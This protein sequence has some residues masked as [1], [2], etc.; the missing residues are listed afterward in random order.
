M[1]K[2]KN[3]KAGV[4][5]VLGYLFSIAVASMVMVSSIIITNNIIEE[6]KSQVAEIEAQRIANYVANAISD[7]VAAKQSMPNADYH[8]KLDLPSAIGGMSYGIQ[9]TDTTVSVVSSSGR[10]LASS[11]TY[12]ANALG[13]SIANNIVYGSDIEISYEGSQFVRTLDFGTGNGYEHSP[14]EAG[15]FR[16]DT[17]R[18]DYPSIGQPYWQDAISPN[19]IPIVVA[20]PSDYNFTDATVKIVLNASNFDYGNATVIPQSKS[21][22]IS[23]VSGI[24]GSS[25]TEDAI[26]ADQFASDMRLYEY[27]EK[28]PSTLPYY[29]AV[30][31]SQPSWYR[32]WELG[33][34]EDVYTYGG[35]KT[36]DRDSIS[37]NITSINSIPG[38]K[39]NVIWNSIKLCEQG[40]EQAVEEGMAPYVN[41]FK[42]SSS[43]GEACF[44]R[45]QVFDKLITPY[46]IDDGKTFALD[47]FGYVANYPSTGDIKM[48]I[49]S[50]TVQIKYGDIYVDSEVPSLEDIQ[51]AIDEAAATPG[52]DVIYLNQ[53]EDFP[54]FSCNYQSL[55][56]NTPVTLVGEY[57]N[58]DEAPLVDISG[59]RISDYILKILPGGS[60]T[61]LIML[62]FSDGGSGEG[63]YC[64]PPT[65]NQ[66]CSGLVLD[67]CN[68]VVVSNCHFRDNNGDGI[69]IYNANNNI[70]TNCESYDNSDNGLL[71]SGVGS[72][73]NCIMYSNFSYSP[74]NGIRLDG[75]ANK[76]TIYA[77]GA[78]HNIGGN[79]IKIY[80][81][82]SSGP[83]IDNEIVDCDI[84]GNTGPAADGIQISSDDQGLPWNPDPNNIYVP[85]YNNIT[86]CKIHNNGESSNAAAGIFLFYTIYNNITDCEIYDTYGAGI[87]GYSS[88]YNKITDCSI[89]NTYNTITDCFGCGDG[90][91]F[92]ENFFMSSVENCNI[93]NNQE[94]GIRLNE[95]NVLHDPDLPSTRDDTITNCR[96]HDNNQAGINL[97]DT[98]RIY[99]SQCDIYRN[100]RDGIYIEGGD[101]DFG[102]WDSENP[103]G[104]GDE[105]KYCNIFANG[106]DGIH[107]WSGGTE[108]LG[109]LTCT[110]IHDNN[111]CANGIAAGHEGAGVYLGG[112][113]LNRKPSVS[114]IYH[115]NFLY[116]TSGDHCAYDQTLDIHDNQWDV[117]GI[118]NWWYDLPYNDPDGYPHFVYP[119]AN[120]PSY[121]FD[122]AAGP[123][124]RYKIDPRGALGAG[125]ITGDDD[126]NP[127]GPGHS[128]PTRRGI[129]LNPSTVIV[130]DGASSLC[131][132]ITDNIQDAINMVIDGGTVYVTGS[133]NSYAINGPL[134]I[135][136]SLRLIGIPNENGAYPTIKIAS[137]ACCPEPYAARTL[138]NI[139]GMSLDPA[140]A[141]KTI[142][143]ENITFDGQLSADRGIQINI[144]NPPATPDDYVSI[145]NCKFKNIQYVSTTYGQNGEAIYIKANNRVSVKNCVLTDNKYGIYQAGNDGRITDCSFDGNQVYGLYLAA[146]ASNNKIYH[147]Y[148]GLNSSNTKDAKNVSSGNLNNQWDNGY[149]SGGNRWASFDVASEGA[150]DSFHG[151]SQ[152]TLIGGDGI[153][154]KPYSI[155]GGG[156]D[157]FPLGGTVSGQ[158][159]VSPPSKKRSFAIDYWNSY[160][161]SIL[162]AKLSIAAGA[163][164]KLYLYY[165]GGKGNVETDS[166]GNVAE[167]YDTFDSAP[168]SSAK[169]NVLGGAPYVSSDGIL[170]LKKLPGGSMVP[171]TIQFIMS[172]NSY[173]SIPQVDQ[174]S[175]GN[176]EHTVNEELY[177]VEAS[178]KLNE[179]YSKNQAS[180]I[181]LSQSNSNY[182]NAYLVSIN[183]NA[184]NPQNP[185]NNLTIHK[186]K[187]VSSQF[188]K[189]LTSVNLPS[190]L[191]DWFRIKSYVYISSNIYA[192][193]QWHYNA[194]DVA[195]I[196]NTLFDLASFS[197]F[198][199][200][201]YMDGNNTKVDSLTV[202]VSNPIPGDFD[203]YDPWSS[204]GIGIGC[205]LL[206]SNDP[207]ITDGS[208]LVDWIRALKT[209]LVPPNVAVGAPESVLYYWSN[210]VVSAADFNSGNP[211]SP[212][213]LLRDYHYSSSTTEFI[214]NGLE[215]NAGYR[216][217]ITKGSENTI[218]P[219]MNVEILQDINILGTATFS[220]T[221]IQQYEAES[222]PITTNTNHPL[223]VRFSVVSGPGGLSAA[224]SW[225]A[226]NSIVIER[227]ERGIVIK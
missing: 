108:L 74:H 78:H 40:G 167:F 35:V 148:F 144:N 111:F 143:I 75:R 204:G 115:N 14:V 222:I 166:I 133:S 1:R 103:P 20:N 110:K 174:P 132:N 84:Y 80:S 89:Y 30:L 206:T 226:V 94:D 151:G 185:T 66:I 219:G 114:R 214:I 129:F 105:V 162:L 54:Y 15:S 48:F 50:S 189:N 46:G 145:S 137:F 182:N 176:N 168:L 25:S 22:S 24:V 119:G 188:E 8:K 59:T 65:N 113:L 95:L 184:T 76:N 63:G 140:V 153:V 180:L 181:L 177:L 149:P 38:L 127:Y 220:S 88:Y 193:D 157:R 71:I 175:P 13:V 125:W 32:Y 197:E 96:I 61:R 142:F 191:N 160:G 18:L 134:T 33:I 70:I 17:Y 158:E 192:Q 47:L 128:D 10:V 34:S 68:N 178:I 19:R 81:D 21:D 150:N 58:K 90:I 171:P 196:N 91:Y 117:N 118:G 211:S 207:T 121:L 53:S 57:L 216:I 9:V 136:K 126:D 77:C 194:T 221:S 190:S 23:G 73:R 203:G 51:A 27:D 72:S 29:P 67:G 164:K 79:G 112:S 131:P 69:L 36:R 56:I 102:R 104:P 165:G 42:Y 163:E 82:S 64:V 44:D 225:W 205:G 152:P 156:Q 39:S 146:T 199:Q 45:S 202:P 86:G 159:Q 3:N 37:F 92:G 169:W 172:K 26:Y 154:D 179:S 198:N 212:G 213:P 124:G 195:E 210:P 52:Q 123:N 208:V 106:D 135:T 161:E 122:H 49:G 97:T 11:S 217:S 218:L 120:D 62:T 170:E 183:A 101:P 85:K 187:Y 139:T 4:S 215:G 155:E 141:T 98:I 224:N 209:P 5:N 99:I 28:S 130:E 100:S 223:Y 200:S 6:K 138:I 186:R 109:I 93:Y 60:G 16:V 83:T 107:M 55:V 31:Q 43:T 2:F 41:C 173:W 116:Y 201:S 12:N 147:N 87:Y 7:A 227:I